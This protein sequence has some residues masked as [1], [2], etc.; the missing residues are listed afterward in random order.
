MIDILNYLLE[1][2]LV[3]AFGALVYLF[4]LSKEKNFV[5]RRAFVLLVVTGM[6]LVPLISIQ[7]SAISQGISEY[8][9]VE[10][11]TLPE[12]V[13]GGDTLTQEQESPTNWFQ[14]IMGCY[15]LVSSFLLLRL[16]LRL[17]AIRRIVAQ[18]EAISHDGFHLID[19]KGQLPTFSFFNF[20]VIRDNDLDTN[21]RAQV[22][23]HELVHINQLHSLDVI[24]LELVS[25]L[26]WYN[27]GAW[28][29]KKAQA[30]N[31]EFI[32]DEEMEKAF[33]KS[34]YQE[35]L[36]RMTIDRMSYVGNYFSKIETLKRINM[37]N[38]QKRKA[39][40]LR[41]GLVGLSLVLVMSILACNDGLMEVADSA[42]M[43]LEVP[44]D[45]QGEM[46][47]LKDKYPDVHFI[48]VEVDVPDNRHDLDLEKFGFNPKTVQFTQLV[49][50]R[51][52]LGVVLA[53]TEDFKKLMEYRRSGDA[54]EVYDFVDE[55]PVPEG[56]M[57]GFYAYAGQNIQ[58]PEEARKNGVEG[59]VFVE[60]V[61]DESGAVAEAR[62]KKGIGGGCDEE[63]IRVVSESPKWQ[64]GKVDGK[65][66]AT[67]LILPVTFVLGDQPT[68][69][70]KKKVSLN[71]ERDRLES[72]AKDMD[73]MVVVGWKPKPE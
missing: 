66:V 14:V 13:I 48:Y 61:I 72:D 24:L 41:L 67:R 7:V 44:A 55:V 25:I 35:L 60:I 16:V 26:F 52:K 45:I 56:D 30:E 23:A 3:L 57:E 10:A 6:I 50:E 11:I 51:N 71:D 36:V 58:Y 4:W 39:S 20:L 59:R 17:W 34:S 46:D 19:G 33:G 31:H 18:G 68:S 54:N 22:I 43:V 62:V 37:M 1:A 28:Y 73:E 8:S 29:F 65:A 70:E 64:P 42:Q 32:A 12:L 21:D 47:Q 69:V 40:K 49:S 38:E 9:P 15:V 63:A 2:N 53:A 5:L 27:P